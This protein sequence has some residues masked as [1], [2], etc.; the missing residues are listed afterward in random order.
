MEPIPTSFGAVWVAAIGVSL[1]AVGCREQKSIAPPLPTNAVAVVGGQIITLE[2]FQNELARRAQAAPGRF[3]E[4][5]E[6]ESLLDELIRLEVLHQKA[7]AAGYDKD[8][9]IAASIKRMIT[10]KYQEDQLTRLGQPKVS[11]EDIAEYYQRNPKQFGT[12]AKVRVALIELKAARTATAEKRAEIARKAEAAL[13]EA[14]AA[15]ADG[16]FELLAQ[17]H[18]EDQAS[19]YRGGDIG[20]LTVGETNAPWHPAVLAAISQLVQP[21]DLAP[22]IETP[23]AFYLV[24]LVER[25]P[26][27]LRP[28]EEVKDGIAYLVARQ[29]AQQQEQALYD[30]LKQ[31]L[32]IQTNYALLES[33][34][35]PANERRPPG[36]PG[37]FNADA[38]TP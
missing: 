13:A 10:T 17:S 8:P 4:A 38:R 1:L 16:T 12:P 32:Q 6:K 15:A 36:G 19:R 34:R 24:K 3:A 2:Q 37:T 26:A 35:P 11:P 21:G 9:Q 22:V 31:G 7:L 20:W 30:A 25:R 28:V 14:K 5:G 27:S 23:A 33:I 18:S 29:K